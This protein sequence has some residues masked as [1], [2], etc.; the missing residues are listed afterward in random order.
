MSTVY[1]SGASQSDWSENVTLDTEN[2][3]TLTN[4]TRYYYSENEPTTTG[5]YWHY[6]DSVAT[7]W[8]EKMTYKV[9]HYQ[10]DLA[11]GA[12]TLYVVWQEDSSESLGTE[13]G[14]GGE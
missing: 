6:V 12:I 13:S 2:N 3:T 4:S 7:P 1:Y 5:K 14:F 11:G 10:E 9:E 8:D